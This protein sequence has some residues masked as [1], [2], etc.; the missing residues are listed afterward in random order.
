VRGSRRPGHPL[1]GDPGG[2][3]GPAV[4]GRVEIANAGDALVVVDERAFRIA[5]ERVVAARAGDKRASS[6]FALAAGV[7]GRR[8]HRVPADD[9]QPPV[10]VLLIATVTFLTR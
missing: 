6:F 1:D 2:R 3:P 9:Q 7:V 8:P 10:T 4:D 5:N